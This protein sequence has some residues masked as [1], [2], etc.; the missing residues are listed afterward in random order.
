MTPRPSR[1]KDGQP[2]VVIP[3]RVTERAAG[4]CVLTPSGCMESTYSV[5]SHGYAQIGWT[6][7]GRTR[8]TLCHR[9]AWTHYSGIQIPHGMTIDHACR[10]RRCVNPLHLRLMSNVLN[11][12]QAGYGDEDVCKN[13]HP[14]DENLAI[15]SGRWKC[16]ACARE[17]SLRYVRKRRLERDL[18]R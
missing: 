1:A 12:R 4:R 13:G 3:P 14:R 8:G 15:V 10:N 2:P 9:A 16:R 11:A 18:M 5:A 6:E 7:D 17:S